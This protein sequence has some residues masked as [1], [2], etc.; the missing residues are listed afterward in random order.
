M[1]LTTIA[2]KTEYNLICRICLIPSGYTNSI[3]FKMFEYC[4][5]IVLPETSQSTD[6][7]EKCENS[8]KDFSSFKIKCIESHESLLKMYSENKNEQSFYGWLGDDNIDNKSFQ[9]TDHPEELIEQNEINKEEILDESDESDESIEEE[10]EDVKQVADKKTSKKTSNKK[11]TEKKIQ[12]TKKERYAGQFDLCMYC[13]KTYSRVSI[14]S[15]IQKVHIDCNSTE[16]HKCDQCENTYKTREAMMRHS[17]FHKN[18][19]PYGCSLCDESFLYWSSRRDHMVYVHKEPYKHNCSMC[20]Y[21]TQN[22]QSFSRHKRQHTG[23]LPFRCK[24]C[25]KPF[26]D[27]ASLNRHM[28]THLTE[29]KFNCEVC[30]KAFASKKYIKTH[31]R[32]HNQERNY[33]CPV[34]S[35]GKSFI[36]NHVLK[37]HMKSTHPEVEIPPSGTI[38]SKKKDSKARICYLERN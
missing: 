14:H 17:R 21:K 11:K 8:L 35:C 27:L 32:T 16:R 36:Q 3:D 6:I 34:E 23:E 20:D 13:G 12:K 24:E 5:G 25:Q 30:N 28:V 15:H 31:M 1:E 2:I 19:K 9:V 10:I 26:I 18:V 33:W 29:K 38:V 4:T 22:S 37:S 7:C